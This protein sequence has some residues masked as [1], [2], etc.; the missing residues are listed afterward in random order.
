MVSYVRLARSRLRS[1]LIGSAPPAAENSIPS[2]QEQFVQVAAL[3]FLPRVVLTAADCIPCTSG[4]P[5]PSYLPISSLATSKLLLEINAFYAAHQLF[6]FAGLF[7]RRYASQ[8]HTLLK[9]AIST[10]RARCA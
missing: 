5:L 9:P 10:S 4:Q 2:R 8:F 1:A 3:N 7:P 6:R